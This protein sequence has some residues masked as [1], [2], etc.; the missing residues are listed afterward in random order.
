MHDTADLTIIQ[1]AEKL[2]VFPELIVTWVEQ[3]YLP[4]AYAL[5]EVDG[6]RIPCADL[7]ALRQR[8]LPGL[9]R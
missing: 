5:Q 9:P 1:A 7:E 6:I 8:G 2:R 3:G 4:H